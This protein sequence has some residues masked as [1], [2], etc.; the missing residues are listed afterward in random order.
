MSY[1][2]G[3]SYQQIPHYVR[4]LEFGLGADCPPG[5]VQGPEGCVAGTTCPPL[6]KTVGTEC[7]P[8]GP[9]ACKSIGAFYNPTEP[10]R[11]KKSC[12]SGTSPSSDG[13]CTSAAPVAPASSIFT[14]TN[15]GI[16]VLGIVGLVA[17][18]SA[19]GR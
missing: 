14:P 5:F 1:S 17:L 8:T 16:G 9:A 4:R 2:Y 10:D 19:G 15:I 13:V 18:I 12:P 11:C 6:F 7:W 3:F